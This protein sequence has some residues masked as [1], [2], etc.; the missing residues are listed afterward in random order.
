[1][2][3]L[4]K[5]R[6]RLAFPLIL[7]CILS[8]HILILSFKYDRHPRSNFHY[9]APIGTIIH[10]A[11]YLF[12]LLQLRAQA[13]AADA[14]L[15]QAEAWPLTRVFPGKK[16]RKQYWSWAMSFAWIYFIGWTRSA[17]PVAMMDL[18][19]PKDKEEILARSIILSQLIMSLTVAF[20]ALRT[21]RREDKAQC[22]IEHDWMCVYCKTMQTD[23]S[24]NEMPV[25]KS[26]V[27]P[28]SVPKG[29]LGTS[30]VLNGL[31]T[32]LAYSRFWAEDH[33]TVYQIAV[34][35]AGFIVNHCLLLARSSSER[36][37]QENVV[38]W[39]A[40]PIFK[41]RRGAGIH[42]F[43]MSLML[44]LFAVAGQEMAERVDWV[45]WTSGD[46]MRTAI[47][48]LWVLEMLVLSA[49]LMNAVKIEKWERK[50][51]CVQEGHRWRCA[52]MCRAKMQERVGDSVQVTEKE[53]LL[54]TV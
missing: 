7:S 11:Y 15:D 53:A 25:H 30:L 21:V 39:P 28:H 17:Y 18:R 36:R 45:I 22:E 9:I 4:T 51:R 41:K 13:K 14:S 43:A 48:L 50:A 6:P 52:R 16:E 31:I 46:C 33:W 2:P 49:G 26:S 8:T 5:R 44:M 23:A 54:I 47:G 40:T 38:P 19:W 34:L 37:A 42:T 27:H 1:M 32:Y 12:R 24:V 29:I 10:S 35:P 20:Q 3:S